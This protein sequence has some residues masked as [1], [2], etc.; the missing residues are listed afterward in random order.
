MKQDRIAAITG[1]LL[2]LFF[3]PARAGDEVV[4]VPKV[5]TIFDVTYADTSTGSLKLDVAWPMA[6][7]SYPMIVYLHGGGWSMGDKSMFRHRMRLLAQS[8]YVVFNANYRLSQEARFPAAVNDAMGAVIYAKE[9]AELYHGDP[10]RVAVMGDSAGG[11]LS[12]MV[13][14]AW[15][16]PYFTPT[17]AG[18]GR[19]SARVQAGVLMYGGYRMDWIANQD[20]KLWGLILTRPMVVAFMGGTPEQ[21]PLEYKKA[22]PASYLDRKDIPPFFIMCGTADSVFPES[23]FLHNALDQKGVYNKAFFVADARHEF[24]YLEN[25]DDFPYLRAILDFLDQVLDNKS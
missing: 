23:D 5:D 2:L 3:S 11:H 14:L 24:N 18:D 7:G 17:Y 6:D 19:Y 13:A 20:P 16:D 25:R 4:V 9:K 12:A 21:K 8:G 22:S 15:D 10:A 1:L